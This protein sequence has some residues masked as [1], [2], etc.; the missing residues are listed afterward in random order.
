MI[1][2]VKGQRHGV[3]LSATN[4]DSR[5]RSNIIDINMGGSTTR[6]RGGIQPGL[7]PG[8]QGQVSMPYLKTDR[9]SML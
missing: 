5:S 6:R 1:S 8:L 2:P 3:I 9:S 7:M 4:N